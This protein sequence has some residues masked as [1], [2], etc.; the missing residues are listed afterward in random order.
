M[1]QPPV[2]PSLLELN[3]PVEKFTDAFIWMA[4]TGAKE[5]K[6]E[7]VG[8]N[9]SGNKHPHEDNIN[10]TVHC[11]DKALA[12]DKLYT[13]RFMV[14]VSHVKI[15]AIWHEG[16]VP[17]DIT[18]EKQL[19]WKT[20]HESD[21]VTEINFRIPFPLYS[22]RLQLDY[23]FDT[24]KEFCRFEF[25]YLDEQKILRPS[26]V[27]GLLNNEIRETLIQE[28]SAGAGVNLDF[29]VSFK[30]KYPVEYKGTLVIWWNPLNIWLT[31]YLV[32][33]AL[34]AGIRCCHPSI[35]PVKCRRSFNNRLHHK[36]KSSIQYL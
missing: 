24:L 35:L 5:V 22:F 26:Y 4:A 32:V 21:V 30:N 13:I 14:P 34:F 18:A 31:T 12:N 11:H 3:R 2:S 19:F 6:Y 1:L 20:A 15:Y 27:T 7:I 17:V 9:F 33:N 23:S 25:D 28:L 8:P 10:F 29:V 16:Q 36:Y